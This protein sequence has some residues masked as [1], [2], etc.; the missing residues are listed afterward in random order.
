MKALCALALLFGTTAFGA[1]IKCHIIYGGENFLVQASPVANP[2]LVESQKI[3][4]YFEFKVV[5]VEAPASAAAIN[6][7]TYALASGEPVLI[8]QSKRRPP[9][10]KNAGK[11]GFTGLNFVYEPSKGSELQYWC[12][13]VD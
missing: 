4:R 3:G 11:H 9:F 13:R 5:Y 1:S 10:P 12:E 7:Y 8:H 6:I 2:Y